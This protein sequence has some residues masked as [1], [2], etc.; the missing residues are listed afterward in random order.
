MAASR[1]W[2]HSA[3]LPG[4]QLATVAVG[5]NHQV[6]GFDN[7][8]RGGNPIAASCSFNITGSTVANEGHASIRSQLQQT[9]MVTGRVQRTM[10]LDDHATVIIGAI[11]FGELLIRFHDVLGAL[12]PGRL[13]VHFGGQLVE[14]SRTVRSN[15]SPASLI[16]T[17]D[18]LGVDEF[19]QPFKRLA[20]FAD[21]GARTFLR[22]TSTEFFETGFDF[23]TDLAAIPGTATPAE[24]FSID[25]R[26]VAPGSGG[27]QRAMQAGVA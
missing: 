11:D 12:K 3:L 19:P 6:S 10:T 20:R 24:V 2:N 16:V 9:G 25:Y 22:I 18:T 23:A 27:L 14:L 21:Q 4:C 15:K 13:P 8:T 1:L 5:R 17:I 26:G 7:A